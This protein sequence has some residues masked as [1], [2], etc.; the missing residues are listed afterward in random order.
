MY[1]LGVHISVL[2]EFYRSIYQTPLQS[3]LSDLTVVPRRYTNHR[4]LK[5][6][7]SIRCL[8]V[9]VELT[10]VRTPLAQPFLCHSSFNV[11]RYWNQTS[12]HFEMIELF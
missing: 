7:A 11:R 6:Y 4:A 5:T 1:Y 9:S 2:S 10:V 3:T 8:I 12:G